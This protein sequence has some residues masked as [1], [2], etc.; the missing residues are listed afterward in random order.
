M[1]YSIFLQRFAQGKPAPLDEAA[2]LEV[3]HP[4]IVAQDSTSVFIR[5]RD[6]SEAE[7]Y[8]D[9]SGLMIDRPEQ[10]GIFDIVAELINR[11][12]V[13]LLSP[14]GPTILRC[15]ADR[16]HLPNEFQNDAIVVELS[17][18]AIQCAIESF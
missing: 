8:R 2:T 6:G 9:P 16:S 4:F 1:S 12:D 14:G 3:L 7:I 11:L 10:G 15:E 18:A 5:A 13:V 17:G